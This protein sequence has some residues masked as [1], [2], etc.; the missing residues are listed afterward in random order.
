[1]VNECSTALLQRK[2]LLVV[3]SVVDDDGIWHLD[4]LGPFAS[5]V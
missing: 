5:Y 2:M 1:M 3:C 4:E